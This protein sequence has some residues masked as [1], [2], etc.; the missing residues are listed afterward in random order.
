MN[1]KRRIV[2]SLAASALVCGL[3]VA[4]HAQIGSGWTSTSVSFV[5][6]TSAGCS[7][8][9]NVF[10]VPS[11]TSGRAERRYATNTNTQRQFQ[12]TV[13][14]NSLGGDRINL[15]QT[16]DQNNGPYQLIAVSKA[17]GELYETE[18]GAKLASYT[19]GTSV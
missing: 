1:V 7:V 13:V 10:K 4:A 15:K 6:Q 5:V 14:V 3:S 9:G 17:N 11:G 8:S 12:G 19:V 2:K 16:F 18:G